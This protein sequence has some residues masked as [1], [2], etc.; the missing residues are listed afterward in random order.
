MT[1]KNEAMRRAHLEWALLDI[2]FTSDEAHQLRRISLTLHR[3]HEREC[4]TDTG[5]IERDEATGRP[6]WVIEWGARWC[7]NKRARYPIPDRQTGALRRLSAL[8][9]ARNARAADE[10]SAYVQTD[11]RGQ[12]L[13]ILRPGDVPAGADPASY[14]SRGLCVY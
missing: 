11:P 7:A 4:G 5:C 12:A 14:Y 13:Y 1:T 8:V 3:W 2:G 6:Y 9:S 10:L